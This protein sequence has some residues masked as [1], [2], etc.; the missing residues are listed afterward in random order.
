MEGS[1]A[2]GTG[3]EEI[4]GAC[5]LSAASIA[6]LRG[7]DRHGRRHGVKRGWVRVTVED[8]RVRLFPPFVPL[9]TSALF[10]LH[11]H[12]FTLIVQP[13]SFSV[14][15]DTEQDARRNSQAMAII[16]PQDLERLWVLLTE[17]A[18]QTNSHRHY[19]ANLHAQAN[20]VKVCTSLSR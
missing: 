16:D 5:V 8:Q 18:E 6:F 3:E 10:L 9:C 15:R 17:L 2:V 11:S 13:F 12:S 14:T 19:T 4:G 20:N 7:A 1:V